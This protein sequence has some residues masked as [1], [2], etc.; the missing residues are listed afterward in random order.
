MEQVLLSLIINALKV[1]ANGRD[2]LGANCLPVDR[3]FFGFGDFWLGKQQFPNS[4]PEMKKIEGG[5]RPVFIFI[6]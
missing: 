3:P 1:T 6:F 5:E 2:E 4:S